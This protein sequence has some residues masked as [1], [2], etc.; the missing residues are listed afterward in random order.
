MSG[1]GDGRVGFGEYW[2][3]SRGP[4]RSRSALHLPSSSWLGYDL[5]GRRPVARRLLPSSRFRGRHLRWCGLAGPRQ[6]GAASRVR[7]LPGSQDLGL[8]S[9]ASGYGETRAPRPGSKVGGRRCGNRHR[10]FLP[11]AIGARRQVGNSV[12]RRNRVQRRELSLHGHLRQSRRHR[13][14]ARPLDGWP[15]A[16]M[17][18]CR[19]CR[20]GHNTEVIPTAHARSLSSPV[21]SAK[22]PWQTRIGTGREPRERL[23]IG[24]RALMSGS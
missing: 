9:T 18:R 19:W 2:L 13:E 12:Q 21:H 1:P 20:P 17:A 6:R 14:A 24:R 22:K 8:Q 10:H 23:L 7:R 15:S 3:R 4:L 11:Q 16:G 5:L